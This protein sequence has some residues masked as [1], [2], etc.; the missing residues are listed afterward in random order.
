[1]V[2]GRVELNNSIFLKRTASETFNNDPNSASAKKKQ[3]M[4]TNKNNIKISR[5]D[6]FR[7]ISTEVKTRKSKDVT[8]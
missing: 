4:P 2:K 3:Q 6:L 7:S 5:F 1:M 8:H